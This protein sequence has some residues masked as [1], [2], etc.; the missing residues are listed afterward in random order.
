LIGQQYLP[1]IEQYLE[2]QDDV[3]LAIC[4]TYSCEEYHKEIEDM[5]ER[6]PIPPMD[7]ELESEV[8]PYFSRLRA[9]AEPAT[10]DS[11]AMLLSKGLK[12]ALR[13]LNM[14][15]NGILGHWNLEYPYPQLYHHRDVFIGKSANELKLIHQF[16]LRALSQYF[17][18]H[19]AL[20]YAEAE[21]LFEA[22]QVRRKHWVKMFR[23]NE[24]LVTKDDG[25]PMAY[26]LS[27]C[28]RSNQ[29]I[30]QLDCWSWDFDGSFSKKFTTLTISWTSKS[31]VIP[32]SELQVYPLRLDK[33]GSEGILRKRGST[34]WSCRKQRFVDY[35][36]KPQ[37]ME[38]QKVKPVT[39]PGCEL[40]ANNVSQTY[41]T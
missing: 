32:I 37:G 28:P 1:N 15:E 40:L 26:M 10:P 31:D 24:V 6:Q 35:G 20:E 36:V 11:E 14:T 5:F 19:L 21:K 16:H 3:S 41:V 4:F 18:E 33:T 12:E 2:N 34:F 23:P 39:W 22:G 7:G 9:D 30:L 27:S 17:N 29:E 38:V 13:L 8:R 25:H